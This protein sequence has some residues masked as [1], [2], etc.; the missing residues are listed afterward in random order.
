MSQKLFNGI[1]NFAIQW[2]WP[3]KSF[4]KNLRFWKKLNSQ[5]ENPLGSVWAHSLSLSRTPRNVNVT[6]RL[7]YRPAPFYVFALV[8]NPKLRSWHSYCSTL[9]TITFVKLFIVPP[10][11]TYSKVNRTML[12]F[13]PSIRYTTP[14]QDWQFI[15]ITSSTHIKMNLDF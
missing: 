14:S 12:H 4:F 8:T 15:E 7:H 9:S 11:T 3:L 1:M 5:S 2:I 6:P 10:L 13:Q